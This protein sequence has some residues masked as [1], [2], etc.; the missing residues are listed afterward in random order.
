MQQ[1]QQQHLR[2]ALRAIAFAAREDPAH[3]LGAWFSLGREQRAE[4]LAESPIAKRYL[5]PRPTYYRGGAYVLP[6]L[7]ENNNHNNARRQRA[8]YAAWLCVEVAML[9]VVD[10]ARTCVVGAR[11]CVDGCLAAA[12]VLCAEGGRRR[13]R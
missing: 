4:L 9:C 2:A 6:P 10:A 7:G 1:Q 11:T 13:R 5:P 8:R 12:L 3:L